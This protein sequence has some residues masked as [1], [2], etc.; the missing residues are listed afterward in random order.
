MISD[1]NLCSKK[2]KL[3]FVCQ[4]YYP[5]RIGLTSICEEL[6]K[7]G[8]KVTVLTGLPNYPKGKVLK[9]YKFFKKRKESINGV[10]VIRCFE[11]GRHK[12]KI[13]LC[14]NYISFYISSLLKVK[15]L[16]KDFDK[17]ICYQHSP[18]TM[19]AAAMKYSKLRKKKFILYCFDLWPESL[20]T[21]NIKES[22]PIFKVVKK[23]SKKI[24]SSCDKII[25]SSKPFIDY[26]VNYHFVD[27]NKIY[28][29]P[30]FSFDYGKSLSSEK[31]DDKIHF[32]YAGNIGKNQNIE[33]II[34][35]VK[36]LKT[37]KKYVVDI[38]GYGSNY[39]KLTK[40]VND[41]S[42][43]DKII[44]HGEKNGNE[45]E[46]FYSIAD[47]LLLTLSNDSLIGMT[48]PLKLQS[49]MSTE[50]PILA[51]INGAAKEAIE[52]Y[53]CGVCVDSGDYKAY[54]K[55][56]KKFLDGKINIKYKKEKRFLLQNNVDELL[57]IIN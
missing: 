40:M 7:N 30:Q 13:M 28:Y 48:L 55:I 8:Y 21:Y 49:Y 1:K 53:K 15:R 18:I 22:N 24:Y 23:I 46:Y 25:V 33:C 42:L 4:Y 17:V 35:A 26:F 56:I 36:L 31:K 38:V 3:L 54:S 45:L 44:F 43:N 50:K 41:Y 6:V 52:E 32:L 27:V 47:A 57:E 5:E 39:D 10:D 20:K 14:V 51:S 2:E 37:S 19:A 12:G 29:L 11:I 34:E 9:E 16:D